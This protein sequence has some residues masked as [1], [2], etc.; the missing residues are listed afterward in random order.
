MKAAVGC[1]PCEGR[2]L[3]SRAW[4][5]VGSQPP[6]LASVGQSSRKIT[7]AALGSTTSRGQLRRPKRRYIA[8]VAVKE[9]GSARDSCISR[10][11]ILPKG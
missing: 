2:V 1:I 8:P 9:F 7:S 11:R 4:L 3:A 10:S 6:A 5:A